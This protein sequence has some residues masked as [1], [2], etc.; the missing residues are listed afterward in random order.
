LAQ[1]NQVICSP[2]NA[3]PKCSLLCPSSREIWQE[4]FVAKHMSADLEKQSV[5]TA[6][7][8][9]KQYGTTA[10][11]D[12]DN[13]LPLLLGHFDV[14]P[15]TIIAFIVKFY[16][17]VF[18]VRA[19]ADFVYLITVDARFPAGLEHIYPSEAERQ[20]SVDYTR[21]TL[22]CM[23]LSKIVNFVAIMTLI[24]FAIFAKVDQC[25]RS[26]TAWL[27]GYL[28]DTWAKYCVLN[29][30]C[31]NFLLP[32]EACFGFLGRICCCICTPCK[33]SF[34]WLGGT[35]SRCC[36]CCPPIKRCFANHSWRELLHGAVYLVLFAAVF[37][38]IQVPFY[39]WRMRI[40][41]DFGFSNALTVKE[42]DFMG[43]LFGGLLG[44]LILG[45]PGKFIL[46]SILQFRFGWL[47]MWVFMVTGIFSTQMN[48]KSLA[49]FA[50][51]RVFPNRMF[52]VG[53]GF[54]LATTTHKDSPLISL[55]RIFYGDG[56]ETDLLSTRDK[57]KGA[58][59]LALNKTR[60]SWAIADKITDGTPRIY[61]ESQGS[62]SSLENLSD[63]QWTIAGTTSGKVGV[64]SGGALREKVL[65]FARLRN[66]S[67]SEIY[68]V[69]GSHEDARA[70]AFVAGLNGSVIGLFDTL[71][72]GDK[73]TQ[74][75]GSTAGLSSSRGSHAKMHLLSSG[76]SAILAL[77]EVVQDVDT[78]DEEEQ[79]K[80]WK[81]APSQA[82]T[83]NEIIAI[84]AHELA[85]PAL[86]HLEQSMVVQAGTS[87]VTFATLGWAAH[88]PLLAT[89][90]ALTVPVLHVG[91][92]AYEHVMGPP[93]E[94]FMKLF[95]NWLS[96]H[97]EY[98][99]D[100]Y[101]ARISDIY[102]MALQS[103]LAKLTV[104]TNQ[105]PDVPFWYEALYYDHPTTAH[106]WAAIEEVKK[107][108]G[109]SHHGR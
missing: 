34:E 54:P 72:L 76:D 106:R 37:F 70:N 98:E 97:K 41:L 99:A 92:L 80:R 107:E 52:A 38:V 51:D 28:A 36:C 71:F 11:V 43:N 48:M 47:V 21:Q 46:L 13:K 22:M 57:S 67:I 16:T 87:F 60:Q 64:R 1:V 86:H 23:L 50:M 4:L 91:A 30:C 69:D 85:H 105:D 109:S 9:V 90:L 32:I 26:L 31:R 49:P 81:S 5:L 88:S 102:G 25:L 108:N 55:N 89:G 18:A 83:D 58:L 14:A 20:Q 93:L 84:L 35:C 19:I 33:M 82:M 79:L 61:A 101:V 24:H 42:S 40:D 7:P 39:Y 104:N 78:P 75:D 10:S 2:C 100:A 6:S 53:R 3:D 77:S 29:C 12:E 96:R 15:R 59:V 73:P 45:I 8:L 63:Q 44:V 62:G 95:S 74:V 56:N 17:L 66:V 103:S 65:G 27:P 94:E 68:M